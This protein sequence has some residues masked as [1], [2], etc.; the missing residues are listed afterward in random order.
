[1]KN[2]N[3]WYILTHNHQTW[4]CK[5]EDAEV[6]SPCHFT[7]T[8]RCLHEYLSWSPTMSHPTSSNL[9][10]V[11][12]A[13][14]ARSDL[15]KTGRVASKNIQKLPIFRYTMKFGFPFEFTLQWSAASMI[16]QNW[17]LISL[18]LANLSHQASGM[19][20]LHVQQTSRMKFVVC[21]P[22]NT[23]PSEAQVSG[24]ENQNQ[25]TEVQE[26]R[27]LH[28]FVPIEGCPSASWIFHW[29]YMKDHESLQ[30]TSYIKWSFKIRKNSS[31]HRDH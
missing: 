29:I 11:V 31:N 28:H 10:H 30:T 15:S 5:A 4:N 6:Q 3:I 17:A 1:M 12:V 26:C 20:D 8:I 25:R 21:Y 18:A 24:P 7:S 13:S 27:W 23:V 14:C 9:H 2:D 19:V 22:W 16:V